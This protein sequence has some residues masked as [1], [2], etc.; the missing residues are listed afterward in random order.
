MS[1]ASLNSE[2]E[3][4]LRGSF[5]L[6]VHA[7]P[8]P[9][10]ERRLDALDTGRYAH[11]AEMAGFVLK[12]HHYPTAP[13]AH[14]LNRV[15]PGLNVVGSIVLNREVGGLNPNAVQAAAD[16]NARVVW[17]P[18]FNA[19]FYSVNRDKGLGIRLVNESGELRSEVHAVLDVVRDH[20]MVLASG[21]VS[22]SE[23]LA[24]FTAAKARG[25]QRMVATHPIG[26]A[27]M[28][29][30]H[31]LVSL[32]ALVEHIFLSCMPSSNET[33][34]AE[35]VSTVRKLGV[36][37]CLVT[38][39]FGLWMNPPP[40]EGMRMAIAALL[41]AGLAPEEVSTLVKANPLHVLGMTHD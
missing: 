8:D 29:E 13:I 38:T 27:S 18:T 40:A 19:D 7:G 14:T 23:T 16:L 28:E 24:L 41:E 4:I 35:M 11:E 22:P 33:T 21:H 36:E 3:E 20:D 31:E 30:L 39:D 1:A 34:P 6:H 32:G 9:R 10:Q 15:Y 12:S 26:I 25:I 17:M 5:D 2:V 37:H